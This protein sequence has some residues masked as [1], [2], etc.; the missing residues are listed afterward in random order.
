MVAAVFP[1]SVRRARS[2]RVHDGTSPESGLP[3]APPARVLIG[4][5]V[6]APYFFF[7]GNILT[8]VCSGSLHVNANDL[9]N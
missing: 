2:G 6:C 5:G 4:G 9:E 8:Q 1:A 3:T 7:L